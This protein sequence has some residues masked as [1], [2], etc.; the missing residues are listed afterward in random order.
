[1]AD[2]WRLNLMSPRLTDQL[3]ADEDTMDAVALPANGSLIRIYRL[4]T[5]SERWP[6]WA[7]IFQTGTP[8]AAAQVANPARSECPE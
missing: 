3:Y 5:A 8:A 6:V 1:M 2:A 7:L 4:K